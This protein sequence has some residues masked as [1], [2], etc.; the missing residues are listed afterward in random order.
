MSLDFKLEVF[1]FLEQP[2]ELIEVGFGFE[3][4]LAAAA[5]KQQVFKINMIPDDMLLLD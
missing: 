5:F 3:C 2:C 1:V 4:Q